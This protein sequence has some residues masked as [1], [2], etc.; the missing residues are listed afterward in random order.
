MSSDVIQIHFGLFHFIFMEREKKVQ[1]SIRQNLRDE[2]NNNSNQIDVG[3]ITLL[4]C[5][6]HMVSVL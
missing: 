6:L 5:I 1:N 3:F 2:T 4:V